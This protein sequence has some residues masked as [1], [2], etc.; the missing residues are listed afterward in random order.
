MYQLTHTHTHSTMAEFSDNSIGPQAVSLGPQAV[1]LGPQAVVLSSSDH[2]P[3]VVSVEGTRRHSVENSPGKNLGR[4][5]CTCGEG[6][7]WYM[8]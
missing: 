5:E 1:V 6:W 8:G 4:C 2:T 3:Q 7:D